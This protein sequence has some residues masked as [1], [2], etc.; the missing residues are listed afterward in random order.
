MELLCSGSV[1]TGR[2][3]FTYSRITYIV[4]LIFVISVQQKRT[5]ETPA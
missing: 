4:E 3:H 5:A 2:A 1:C